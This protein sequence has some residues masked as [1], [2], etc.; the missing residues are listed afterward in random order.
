MNILK[1]IYYT[2]ELVELK[3]RDSNMELLRIVSMVLV[4]ISHASY[5]SLNP[6]AQ[7]D[8]ST[9]L[10]SAFLRVLAE[11]FSV[12]CVNVFVLIS[13][14]YGIKV[15]WSRFA[16]LIFQVVFISISIYALMRCLGLVQAISISC[17]LSY[18]I[19]LE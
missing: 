18:L 19:K 15:R 12:V 14:W 1:R 2:V 10:D 5:T 17:V 4:L 3:E 7:A 11:S 9:S 6:P 16:E 13:G 8:I